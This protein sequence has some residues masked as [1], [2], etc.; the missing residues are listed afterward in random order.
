VEQPSNS[1][2]FVEDDTGD[3]IF[4]HDDDLTP[5]I[6]KAFH[7]QLTRAS[8]VMSASAAG[9]PRFDVDLGPSGGP[10]LKGF[11]RYK[12]AVAAEV[13]WLN[14]RLPLLAGESWCTL[15]HTLTLNQT[16]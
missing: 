11:T 3:L 9:V 8:H 10:V 1:R 7:V 13:A 4:I 12:E 16:S 6:A 14:D 2:V 15:E 5:E